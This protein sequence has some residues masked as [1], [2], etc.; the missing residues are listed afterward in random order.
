M[1]TSPM[2]FS[3]FTFAPRLLITSDQ[4][5]SVSQY[6]KHHT[7]LRT[8]F[9]FHHETVYPRSVFQ[10]LFAARGCKRCVCCQTESKQLTLQHASTSKTPLLLSKPEEAKGLSKDDVSCPS[11]WQ[12]KRMIL[13][14]VCER[15]HQK[16]K[17]KRLMPKR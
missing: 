16:H 2:Q 17:V 15:R 10:T 1:P 14:A 9:T 3:G 4:N 8:P 13:H 12:F 6:D 7:N 11:Y 5:N